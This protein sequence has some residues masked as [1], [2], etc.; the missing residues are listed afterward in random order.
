MDMKFRFL[1]IFLGL[2]L[3]SSYSFTSQFNY[4]SE[5]AAKSP[6]A[7]KA[8]INALEKAGDRIFTSGD[9]EV[10]PKGLLIGRVVRDSTGRERV[11][12]AADYKRLTFL[13]VI[14]TTPLEAVIESDSVIG[15]NTTEDKE[16]SD[17]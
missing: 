13:K 4:G 8:L 11:N 2:L 9:G 1:I 10:F 12:L 3:F 5:F 15:E 14:R 17:E 6:N 16:R 7:H